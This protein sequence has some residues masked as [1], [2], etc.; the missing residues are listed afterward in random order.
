ML[1]EKFRNAL[2]IIDKMFGNNIRW[3]VAGS[4]N[5]N[6][7]GMDVS[8]HDLDIVVHKKDL[9][10]ISKLFSEYDSSEVKELNALSGNPAYEVKARINGVEV[11]F[12]GG[13]EDDIYTEKLVKSKIEHLKLDAISVPCL[14]LEAEIDCYNGTGRGGRSESIKNFLDGGG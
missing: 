7:H 12:F 5:L 6:L 10:T 2:K 3:T 11:Q 9:K 14:L 8:P 4:A 13:G 1:N